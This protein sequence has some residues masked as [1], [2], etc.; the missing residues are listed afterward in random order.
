MM[1]T[2]ITMKRTKRMS[3]TNLTEYERKVLYSLE[4][5]RSTLFS[6]KGCVWALYGSILGGLFG[7]VLA[8]AF[9]K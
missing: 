9:I 6:I 7:F 4:D 3:M 1:M 8:A 2:P 5:L